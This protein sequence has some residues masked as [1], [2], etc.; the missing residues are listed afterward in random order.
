MHAWSL[1]KWCLISICLVCECWTGFL[2]MLMALLLSQK[3]GIL[4]MKTPKSLNCC[5]IHKICAQLPT[6]IYSASTIEREIESYFLLDQE[7]SIWPRNWQVPLLLF[8]S[9]LLPASEKPMSSKDDFLGYHKPKFWVPKRYLKMRLS[10][11]K[12]DSLGHV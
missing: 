6:S 8:L 9:I 5:F 10:A 2:V 7:T 12:W 3:I 4:F 11:I 1:M